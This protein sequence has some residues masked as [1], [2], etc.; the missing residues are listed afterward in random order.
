[1]HPIDGARYALETR[2]RH[3]L[4]G[5]VS[6]QPLGSECCSGAFSKRPLLFAAS[7]MDNYL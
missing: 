3:E 6:D 5:H 4:F 7:M 1:M 2:E